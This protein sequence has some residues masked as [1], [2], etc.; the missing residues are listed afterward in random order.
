MRTKLSTLAGRFKLVGVASDG[1]LLGGGGRG[2]SGN[3]RTAAAA[4]AAVSVATL[5][6]LLFGADSFGAAAD[7]GGVAFLGA[8]PDLVNSGDLAGDRA[9]RKAAA[10]GVVVAIGCDL[11]INEGSG[12]AGGAAAASRPSAPTADNAFGATIFGVIVDLGGVAARTEGGGDGVS[13]ISGVTAVTA[14][15]SPAAKRCDDKSDGI[16]SPL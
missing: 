13:A 9:V 11:T 16:V 14:S 10:A 5:L 7:R 8:F 15:S 1:T 3:E 12:G 6:R 4:A 2:G